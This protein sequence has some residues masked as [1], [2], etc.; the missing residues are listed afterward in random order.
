M[1]MAHRFRPNVELL[2][3]LALLSPLACFPPP[4]LPSDLAV[5]LTT[6]RPVYQQG[7]PV[8]MTLTETNISDHEVSVLDGCSI[9][10]FY[11][12]QGGVTVWDSMPHGD[13]TVCDSNLVIEVNCDPVWLTLHPDE[14]LTRSAVWDGQSDLNGRYLMTGKETPLANPT[15]LFIVNNHAPGAVPVTINIEPTPPPP[16]SPSDPPLTLPTNRPVYQQSQPVI[17]N[18]VLG[19]AP[20]AI[21]ILPV[22][23]AIPDH[24]SHE[25]SGKHP[26]SGG[27]T[28]HH[29][30]PS[31]IGAGVL[32]VANTG[33]P[34]LGRVVHPA[35]TP[36]HREAHP[37]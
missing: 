14:S 9:D 13:F 25:G 12:T 20:A 18:Q 29:V 10:S 16:A 19:A 32:V 11:V 34:M 3:A 4:A 23:V 6:D 33:R 27:G 36:S 22:P 21:F 2:E 30:K 5:T 28:P 8:T 26:H 24:H 7:Q 15:G 1:E 31:A 17:N 37:A 35:A